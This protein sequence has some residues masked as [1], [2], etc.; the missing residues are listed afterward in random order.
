[1]LFRQKLFDNGGWWRSLVKQVGQASLGDSISV[2]LHKIDGLFDTHWRSYFRTSGAL[3]V[4]RADPHAGARVSRGN[5]RRIVRASGEAPGY[6]RPGAHSRYGYASASL[7]RAANWRSC[8][9]PIPLKGIRWKGHQ[10]SC[11]GLI[12][13]HQIVKVIE[14]L[15]QCPVTHHKIVQTST[16]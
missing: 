12:T 7:P 9:A 6:P 11:Q 16:F 15:H 10:S 8:D 1:M 2:R 5:R 14:V 3:W 13:F 4:T